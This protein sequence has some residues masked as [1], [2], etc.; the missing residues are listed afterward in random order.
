MRLLVSS[1]NAETGI[2]GRTPKTNNPK[3]PKTLELVERNEEQLLFFPLWE[4]LEKS[5]LTTWVFLY[6]INDNEMRCE[7]SQ[8]LKMDDEERIVS[9]GERII[10][11]YEPRKYR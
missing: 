11:E 5:T 7:L 9:W 3:G 8:P 4:P 6:Y 2:E 10:P 1:G